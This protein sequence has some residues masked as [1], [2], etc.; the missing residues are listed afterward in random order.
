VAQCVAAAFFVI[1]VVVSG[2]LVAPLL[3]PK[4]SIIPFV[5]ADSSFYLHGNTDLFDDATRSALQSQF[6]WIEG[7]REFAIFRS[8]S[9]DVFRFAIAGAKSKPAG[10]TEVAPGIFTTAVPQPAAP[11]KTMMRELAGLRGIGAV[12]GFSLLES[13]SGTTITFAFSPTRDRI[14]GR[15]AVIGG[16]EPLLDLSDI[17][18][19]TWVTSTY[20]GPLAGKV[21]FAPLLAK[22]EAA[23]SH[24]GAFDTDTY[25][26]ARQ[27]MESLFEGGNG[28]ITTTKDGQVTLFLEGRRL[29]DV[30]PQVNRYLFAAFP[31]MNAEGTSLQLGTLASQVHIRQTGKGFEA[32]VTG[33]GPI[34]A[35]QEDEHGVQV[36]QSLADTTAQPQTAQPCSSD[37]NGR[38]TLAIDRDQAPQPLSAL[39]ALQHIPT[40]TFEETVD[41]SLLFCGYRAENVDN[42]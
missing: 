23:R 6:P 15:A 10:F 14:L 21:P 4:D 33:F 18:G 25:R 26:G 22:A 38:L 39:L 3:L 17:V 7:S 31:G 41:K 16:T 12:Q 40:I 5:P 36:V 37:A 24:Y 9:D 20:S 1:A 42:K 8:A 13:S 32:S 30:L 34:L 2:A 11:Q 28:T 35:L 29:V 27:A 19:K